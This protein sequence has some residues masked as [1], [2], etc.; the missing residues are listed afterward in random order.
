MA[1]RKRDPPT[2][3]SGTTPPQAPA[4]DA[5]SPPDNWQPAGGHRESP[6]PQF[7]RA[8]FVRLG[9]NAAVFFG[10]GLLL[11]VLLGL[12][13]RVGWV[14][15]SAPGVAGQKAL[16]G[17]IYTCPM[18]PQIRQPSPGRCPICSMP[19]VLVTADS[20]SAQD[21]SSVTIEPA[22]RRGSR[23]GV[24]ESAQGPGS[25]AGD[26]GADGSGQGTRSDAPGRH[27]GQG[28]PPRRE[29]RPARR[30]PRLATHEGRQA[31]NRDPRD[32]TEGS[33]FT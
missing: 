7:D 32:S 18:H 16:P 29:G 14:A 21:A 20:A 5:G 30:A 19:L 22:A 31:L 11:I 15:G 25:R 8:F 1:E 10:V 2:P 3:S 33:R 26:H 27:R 24:P 6:R 28:T 23:A 13:Q 4:T 12:L 17:A 9:L